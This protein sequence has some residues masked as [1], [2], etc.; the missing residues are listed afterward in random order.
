MIFSNVLPQSTIMGR[1]S[2]IKDDGFGFKYPLDTPEGEDVSYEM[3]IRIMFPMIMSEN[4]DKH[5]MQFR[6]MREGIEFAILPEVFVQHPE[7]PQEEEQ[8]IM[9]ML[10]GMPGGMEAM[11][12]A[13]P[14][15]EGMMMG[16]GDPSDAAAAAGGLDADKMA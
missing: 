16:G 4:H 15:M 3:Y 12:G 10:G 11:M 8:D 6:K 9:S 13:M 1:V 14:G 5:E 2:S 7:F